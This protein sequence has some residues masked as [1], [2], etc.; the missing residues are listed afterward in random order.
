[1]SGHQNGLAVL[2]AQFEPLESPFPYYV[3]RSGG[4]FIKRTDTDM[5][6]MLNNQFQSFYNKYPLN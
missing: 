4:F 2:N 5:A 3:K 1:M 6:I